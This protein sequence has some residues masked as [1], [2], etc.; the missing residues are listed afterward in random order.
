MTEGGVTGC[1]GLIAGCI[2]QWHLSGE[3]TDRLEA[4]IRLWPQASAGLCVRKQ[5][6][7]GANGP[8]SHTGST[9]RED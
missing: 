2:T 3:M 6:R 9:E 4:Q 5:G 1:V 8:D 7:L